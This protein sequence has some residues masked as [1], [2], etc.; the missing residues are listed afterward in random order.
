[1]RV[2]VTGAGGM[3]GRK[4][5]QRLCDADALMG[6]TVSALDLVD[7]V[8][9]HA[10]RRFAGA[11]RCEADDLAAPGMT[12]RWLAARPDVIF[13]LAAIVS[14]EAEADFAKGYRVNLDGVRALLD[15][16]RREAE[17]TAGVYRPR[18]VFASSIAVFGPPF[19]DVIEDDFP[20]APQSSYGA[21]KAMGEL[22]VND[23]TR[24][25]F[26]DGISLRLP[27]ICVRPGKPNAAASGFFSDIIREPLAG[28][29]TILPVERDVRHSFA[30]PRSAVRFLTHAAGIDLAPLGAQR[31]LNLPGVSVTV[32]EQIDS[33]RR[34]AGADAVNLIAHRPDPFIAR[35]VHSWPRA[36]KAD[37]AASLGFSAETS[38][39]AIVRAHVE[40]ELAA[41]TT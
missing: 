15:S 41:A 34:I 35:L 24:R 40:D 3:I 36:F 21:Q 8:A 22:L 33:L 29:R 17:A 14:G 10:P 2:L 28:R 11:V 4:L 19:P 6:R 37:R 16:I 20:V 13:H 26:I 18:F 38:F 23:T 39:D 25:G 9:P 1:M 12:E 31:A 32:D 7:I 27:T 5:I 30:S